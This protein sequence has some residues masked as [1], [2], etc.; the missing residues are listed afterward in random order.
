MAVGCGPWTPLQS[1]SG[2]EHAGR[3]ALEQEGAWRTVGVLQVLREEPAQA[4]RHAVVSL[5]A[6]TL[7]SVIHQ[8][9]DA[10]V[11]G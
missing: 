5:R 6:H 8:F 9:F 2:G 1:V 7:T 11:D 3:V 4:R 10:P